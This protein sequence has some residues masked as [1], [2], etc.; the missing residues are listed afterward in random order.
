LILTPQ[1]KWNPFSRRFYEIIYGH[2]LHQ[3]LRIIDR[4][5]PPK[6]KP[7]ELAKTFLDDL[8]HD[9]VAYGEFSGM[10]FGA[11]RG[12]A[13]Q[14]YSK[15]LGV[16]ER[17]LAVI[18]REVGA[19]AYDRIVNV[20]AAEGY[21]AIGLALIQP[22]AQV[23]VFEAMDCMRA[24][25]ADL[26]AANNVAVSIGGACDVLK[27]A[28]ALEE[29]SRALL[30]VDVEGFEHELLLPGRIAGLGRSDVLLETHDSFKRQVA[31]EMIQRFERTHEV[32]VT[33]AQRR[34]LADLP[35]R[36]PS[37]LTLRVGVFELLQEHRSYPQEWLW[38][39][40]RL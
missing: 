1:V 26:A 33:R 27:L 17:E 40:A 15:L 22:G 10:K 39:Q 37:S 23:L 12:R 3:A 14:Y 5:S 30:V 13:N 31:R 4:L 18:W 24:T 8:L 11:A 32:R 2:N 20:G 9:V 16:Y 34:V 28:N 36:L 19:R 21:Y 38:M 35:F 25:L 7:I 29:A 6:R